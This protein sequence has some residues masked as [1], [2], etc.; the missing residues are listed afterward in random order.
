[1]I[2]EKANYE[3]ANVIAENNILL[4][5]ESENKTI[6]YET[7][8]KGVKNL[9]SNEKNGFYLI[10]KNNKNK[11]IGQLMITYEWSDWHNNLIWWIQSVYVVNSFRKKGIFKQLF[12]NIKIRAIENN[13][14]TLR[15][16]VYEN[17]LL[18]KKAYEKI[19]MSK[20]PYE[21]FEYKI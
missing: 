13:V 21:F 4:A 1:M 20:G 18:A 14:D 5:K 19:K 15:L 10:A 16:Y 6:D 17:N 11:I 2:V 7:V 12:N 8:L 3:D 9:I